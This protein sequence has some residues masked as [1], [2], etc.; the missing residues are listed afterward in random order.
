MC[1]KLACF[2]GSLIIIFQFLYLVIITYPDIHTQHSQLMVEGEY[3]Y[4]VCKG[5]AA[6]CLPRVPHLPAYLSCLIILFRR[7]I[8]DREVKYDLTHEVLVGV[9][10][11]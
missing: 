4:S 8:I 3:I 9:L 6:V 5:F 7:E 2:L 11:V 1:K 10:A